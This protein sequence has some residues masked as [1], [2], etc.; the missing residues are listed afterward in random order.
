[1]HI[2]EV[3]NCYTPSN[4]TIKDC[5]QISFKNQTTT[6]SVDVGKLDPGFYYINFGCRSEVPIS[7]TSITFRSTLIEVFPP[8]PKTYVDVF[9]NCTV[10]NT[11]PECLNSENIV[12]TAFTLLVLIFA[13]L[14]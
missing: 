14:F 13:F 5:G 4:S 12:K 2:N 6:Q 10:N 3:M 9:Y 11:L 7:H 1:M 8:A